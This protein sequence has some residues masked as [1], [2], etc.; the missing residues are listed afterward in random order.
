VGGHGRMGSC[1][2]PWQMWG[3][4]FATNWMCH[5]RIK[6]RDAQPNSSRNNGNRRAAAPNGNGLAG[7]SQRGNGNPPLPGPRDHSLAE[8]SPK[9]PVPTD[10]QVPQTESL[11]PKPMESGKS[12]FSGNPGTPF[13]RQRLSSR[14][15]L[16]SPL[17]I[18]SS[19]GS[20]TSCNSLLPAGNSWGRFLYSE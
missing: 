2:T 19:S 8:H 12:A 17:A 15:S 20:S 1:A 14:P 13:A 11:I 3:E 9:V 6:C 7:W 10:A 18:F 16:T 4:S 5:A